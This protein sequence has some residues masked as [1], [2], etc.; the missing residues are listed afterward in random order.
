MENKNTPAKVDSKSGSIEPEPLFPLKGY[1]I[2]NLIFWA[3]CI[4]QLAIL[5][6]LFKD[7]VGL[8]FF[9]VVLGAG[10]TIVSAYDCI[11][12]RIVHKNK[13]EETGEN[14]PA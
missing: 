8:V 4:L 14:K 5:S 10:F 6:W 2:L 1:L 11:Y 7:I 12:D 9:F 3:Y 13:S